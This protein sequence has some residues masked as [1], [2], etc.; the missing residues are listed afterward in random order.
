MHSVLVAPLV[1][2]FAVLLGCGGGSEY[3]EQELREEVNRL[4]RE[5]GRQ[6]SLTEQLDEYREEAKKLRGENSDLKARVHE[7]ELKAESDQLLYSVSEEADK[8]KAL[9][10]QV[11]TFKKD[12]ARLREALE[13]LSADKEALAKDLKAA[14]ARVTTLSARPKSPPPTRTS[15]P[16]LGFGSS[17]P[18]VTPTQ[19]KP[20]VAKN[21]HWITNSSRKRHNRGCRYFANSKGRY[22]S[23]N[24]GI[25]C[26][27][28][29]G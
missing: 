2:L 3:T 6:E 10:Q 5:L 15:V 26:G 9:S 27:I 4:E 14:K 29:G 1:L 16:A 7:F 8:L 21:T 13:A 23:A 17:T 24:E 11:T 28:C 12:N 25:A 22:C 19:A 20:E 18:K